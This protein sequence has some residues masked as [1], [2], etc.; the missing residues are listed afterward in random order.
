MGY[1]P[2]IN[3]LFFIGAIVMGM[4]LVHPYF[5][6]IS[7]AAAMMYY[8]LLMGRKG[9]RFLGSMM[10]LAVFLSLLNPFLNTRGATVLFQYLNGRNFTLEALLYGIATGGMFFTVI[11]WFS[12]YNRL[13]TS[14]KFLYLFGWCMPAISLLLSMVLRLVPNFR[15][16]A[17]VIAGARKC[18][19]KAPSGGSNKEKLAHSVE[20]LSVLTS[21]ALEGAVM[22]ADSMKSRGYGSGRRSA[23]SIYRFRRQDMV[24]GLVMFVG[25]ALVVTAVVLGR[26]GIIYEPTFIM[27]KTDIVSIVG[28]AGYGCFLLL[29]SVLHI[30]EDVTWHILRSKI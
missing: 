15:K 11:L 6:C 13:M 14:D 28:L 29:P 18:V 9:L 24:V 10:V 17:S 8:L 3:F 26:T 23:F 5:L 27:P 19:G 12:C 2:A 25:G 1:H 30:W 7:A 21:W 22:T 4:F 20:I 16:K